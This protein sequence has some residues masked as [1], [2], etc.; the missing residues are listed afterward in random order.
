[1]E[2]QRLEPSP[3]MRVLLAD[4]GMTMTFSSRDGGVS[5]A[6]CAGVARHGPSST[7]NDRVEH[8]SSGGSVAQVNEG[9][10]H[11]WV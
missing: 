1:M 11:E 5:L 4:G 8:R 3:L 10:R 9:I 6:G 2:S 7:R